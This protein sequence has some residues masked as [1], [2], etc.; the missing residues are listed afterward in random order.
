MCLLLVPNQ[1]P[2]KALKLWTILGLSYYIILFLLDKNGMNNT[3]V[4]C[5]SVVL[6]WTHLQMDWWLTLDQRWEGSIIIASILDYSKEGIAEICQIWWEQGLWMGLV[7]WKRVDFV[8]QGWVLSTLTGMSWS[9]WLESCNTR[10]VILMQ[11]ISRISVL[12]SF[13]RS[14]GTEWRCPWQCS[15]HT[16]LDLVDW[17]I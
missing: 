4:E 2:S 14:I 10:L 5:W 16:F 9:D 11:Y 17:G 3:Q 13:S 1:R 7:S 12:F 6:L 15:T 8:W